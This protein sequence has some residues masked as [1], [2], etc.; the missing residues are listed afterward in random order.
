MR[1]AE[2]ST[3]VGNLI[4]RLTPRP[5]W[6]REVS[7]SLRA[8][9][10]QQTL[11]AFGYLSAE[12]RSEIIPEKADSLQARVDYKLDLGPLYLLDSVR[13]F[14]RVYIRPGRYFYHHHLSALQRG[15][16]FSL[17]ALEDDRTIARAFL[18]EHGYYY[19]KPEH[20]TYEADTLISPRKVWLRTVLSPNTPPEAL[21]QWK[22][23]R[24]ILRQLPEDAEAPTTLATDSVALSDSVMLYYSGCPIV[25][26]GVLKTRIRMKRGQV[27]RSTDEERTLSALTGLSAFSSVEMYFSP[28]EGGG[29]YALLGW[30]YGLGRPAASYLLR[31][32][33]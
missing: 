23:G 5:V 17:E 24:V 25:R 22:L 19:L 26:P 28:R 7:P 12:V 16:P 9:V 33:R 31:P 20:I 18:R 29:R 4:R 2:D 11:R 14:P 21:R 6:M 15:R 10:A 1:F 27:Y 32:A 13:Y 30:G 3:F 8:K